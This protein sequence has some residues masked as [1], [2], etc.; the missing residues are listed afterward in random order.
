MDVSLFRKLTAQLRKM[1]RRWSARPWWSA[2]LGVLLMTLVVSGPLACVVHCAALGEE[3]TAQHDHGGHHHAHYQ[4][5][6]AV[7][8]S[9][10]SHGLLLIN[11][12]GDHALC[13]YVMG[14]SSEVAPSALTIGVVLLTSIVFQI[15]AVGLQRVD[16]KPQLRLLALPPPLAPPRFAPDLA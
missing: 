2:S 4:P 5:A 12:H 11:E 7:T 1:M 13:D 16:R 8:A 6:S 9:F 15:A 14:Q 3:H 10:N